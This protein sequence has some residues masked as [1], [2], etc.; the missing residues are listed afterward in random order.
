MRGEPLENH[1]DVDFIRIGTIDFENETFLVRE[2]QFQSKNRFVSKN[3][4]E[5]IIDVYANE[6]PIPHFHIYNKDKSFEACIRI[7]ENLYFS[8]GGKYT[9][10]FNSKQCRQLNEYLKSKYSKGPIKSTVWEAIAFFW[11]TISSYDYPNK[12]TTQPHYEAMNSFRDVI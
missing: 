5:C 8:H 3:I 4:G 10:K 2:E 11:D 1:K 9:S 6:G 7:Y 12:C